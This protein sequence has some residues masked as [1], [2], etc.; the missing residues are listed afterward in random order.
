MTTWLLV[1]PK[2]IQAASGKFVSGCIG[3]MDDGTVP[4][5]ITAQVRQAFHK[6]NR[7]LE[8]A[9]V[10][11]SVIVEITIATQDYVFYEH[12]IEKRRFVGETNTLKK[13]TC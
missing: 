6:I 7:C 5:G 2:N 11:R 8:E 4:E 1:P 12:Q 3:I 9:N 10:G 13:T